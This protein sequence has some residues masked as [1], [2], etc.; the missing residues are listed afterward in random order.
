[1]TNPVDISDEAVRATAEVI[2]EFPF[3]FRLAAADMLLA[4]RDAVT[5]AEGE[6][7]RLKGY[8]PNMAAL[9]TRDAAI[10]SLRAELVEARDWIAAETLESDNDAIARI[11]KIL[12]ASEQK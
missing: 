12:K 11:N 1:M 8:I 6:V 9:E 10:A 4:L 7:A 3:A 5:K 2:K